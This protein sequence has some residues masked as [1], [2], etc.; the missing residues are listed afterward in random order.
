MNGVVFGESTESSVLF[1]NGRAKLGGLNAILQDDFSGM[2]ATL[3]DSSTGT[4]AEPLD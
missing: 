4:F 1:C 2:G 3:L